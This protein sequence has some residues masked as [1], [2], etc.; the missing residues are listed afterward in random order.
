[1]SNSVYCYCLEILKQICFTVSL[2]YFLVHLRYF[3]P[4]NMRSSIYVIKVPVLKLFLTNFS[5]I[6]R[7]ITCEMSVNS[8][9][10]FSNPQLPK[11]LSNRI[12]YPLIIGNNQWLI[13]W[14]PVD[15]SSIAHWC[16]WFHWWDMPGI[17]LQTGEEK[18]NLF[19][20]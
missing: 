1:M 13:N 16:H 14:L 20:F 15:Y 7:S 8:L 4:Q 18:Q 2:I 5:R 3:Q 10:I 11:Q 9:A 17:H 19:N 12:D 6:L